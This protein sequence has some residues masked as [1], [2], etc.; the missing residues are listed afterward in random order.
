ME[1]KKKENFSHLKRFLKKH[2]IF[3]EYLSQE[4]GFSKSYLSAV[5]NKKRVP[6]D[7]FLK[8][9]TYVVEHKLISPHEEF[10][11]IRKKLGWK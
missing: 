8:I 7:K 11:E 6:S 1:I 4:T 9:F 5:L 2:R 10:A 3:H